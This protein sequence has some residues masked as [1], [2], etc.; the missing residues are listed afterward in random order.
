MKNYIVHTDPDE[1]HDYAFSKETGRKVHISEVSLSGRN[2]YSCLGCKREMQAVLRKI[3]GMKPYFRHDSKDVK[4]TERCTF[5]NEDA[6][7]QIAT[8]TLE[9]EKR[10]RLPPLYKYPPKGTEGMAIPIQPGTTISATRV[11]KYK[12]FYEDAHGNIQSSFEFSEHM[13]DL[14]FKADVVFYNEENEP[15]LFI[16]LDKKDQLSSEFQAGLKRLTVNTILVSIPKDSPQSIHKALMSGEKTKWLYNHDEQQIPYFPIPRDIAEGIPSIDEDEGN[17][18][19][20]SFDCRKVQINNLIRAINK[21][22]ESEQYLATE[23]AVRFAIGETELAIVRAKL[24]Q[25]EFEKQ[26]TGEAENEYS[27]E[28]EHIRERR[29]RIESGRARVK[30][31]YRD[32]GERYKTKRSELAEEERLLDTNIREEE[33]ALRGT[34][35]TIAELTE[36]LEREFREKQ[37]KMDRQ[38]ERE[39]KSIERERERISTGIR[40]EGEQ[41]KKSQKDIEKLP[42]EFAADQRSQELYLDRVEESEKR[43]IERIEEQR[44]G[45]SN[46]FEGEGRILTKK[47]E[48]LRKQ[49]YDEIERRDATGTSAVSKRI[50]GLIFA[51]TKFADITEAQTA[52]RRIQKDRGFVESSAF[53]EWVSTYRCG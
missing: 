45:L 8:E 40:D 33:T 25:I 12:Y 38:F 2:D 49:S 32:L 35:T 43:E 42:G 41:L 7:R 24:Q 6:R 51:R 5:R 10:V 1:N 36:D 23:Q 13:G 16:Q 19:E 53:E 50:G 21:Q 11:E 37:Q 28:L 9:L 47:F 26:Y 27:G 48:G 18:F 31:R 14:L 34:G 20:E 30:V 17:L 22:L 44:N 4:L 52:C 46:G 39:I 29:R 3:Y 15:I